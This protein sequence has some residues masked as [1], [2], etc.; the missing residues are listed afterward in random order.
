MSALVEVSVSKASAHQRCGRAGRVQEGVCFRLFA[1]P[2]FDRLSKYSVPEILRVPLE[3]LCLHI[4]VCVFNFCYTLF[5]VSS[6][7]RFG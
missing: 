1:R 7:N 2:M 5:E 6:F 4:M 3:E